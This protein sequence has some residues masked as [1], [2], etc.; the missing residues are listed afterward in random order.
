MLIA[1]ESSRTPRTNRTQKT[2]LQTNQ[3]QTIPLFILLNILCIATS[4]W[5][6]EIKF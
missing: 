3:S 1:L 5:S 4:Q 6:V 2:D